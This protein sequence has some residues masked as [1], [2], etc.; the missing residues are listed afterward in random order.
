M[1]RM[2]CNSSGRSGFLLLEALVG[3]ALFAIFLS[4]VGFSLLLSHQ[5]VVSAG[6][7]AR[8]IF[9]AERALEGTKSLR[10]E[11]FIFLK[12]GSHAIGVGTGTL[13]GKWTF[14]GASLS[15]SRYIL[16]FHI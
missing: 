8:G 14:T 6:D 3:F 1:P 16:S 13:L 5:G 7:R 10:N 15:Q 11:R 4:A 9:L 2:G 12:D